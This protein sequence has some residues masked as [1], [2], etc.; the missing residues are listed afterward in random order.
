M[1]DWLYI[2]IRNCVCVHAHI[3]DFGDVNHR[4]VKDVATPHNRNQQ[5]K[6]NPLSNLYM[7]ERGIY[8]TSYIAEKEKLLQIPFNLSMS[9]MLINKYMREHVIHDHPT[10]K[11]YFR[12]PLYDYE[13]LPDAFPDKQEF[14]T[15]HSH[16]AFRYIPRKYNNQ[17]RM[18]SY[19]GVKQ[20]YRLSYKPWYGIWY[21]MVWWGRAQ[22]A[23]LWFG[24]TFHTR[25]ALHLSCSYTYET[26]A[27][28]IRRA[29][30]ILH[31]SIL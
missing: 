10:L 17:S 8:A 2:Y 1:W 24:F 28:C 16:Q 22:S 21:D 9:D 30:N 7:H 13:Y 15:R 6:Q 31:Q 25:Y 18:V 19:P 3:A 14:L 5:S 4:Y 27:Y 23:H 12:R 20:Y 29:R 26:A 11:H